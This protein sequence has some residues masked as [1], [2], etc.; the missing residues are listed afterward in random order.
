MSV[1]WSYRSDKSCLSRLPS[2]LALITVAAPARI[3]RQLIYQT[4]VFRLFD[5]RPAT[6][7][8]IQLHRAGRTF[9][10]YRLLSEPPYEVYSSSSA[11][12]KYWG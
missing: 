2:D 1:N 8:S 4:G 12:F 5:F 11:S 9:T 7:R 3:T 6:L 10:N